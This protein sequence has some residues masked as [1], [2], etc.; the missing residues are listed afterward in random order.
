MNSAKRLSIQ[1][2]VV[3]K[4]MQSEYTDT[5]VTKKYILQ[6]TRNRCEQYPLT[7]FTNFELATSPTVAYEENSKETRKVLDNY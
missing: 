2:K 5:D 7:T 3:S 6:S 4:Q 1:Q